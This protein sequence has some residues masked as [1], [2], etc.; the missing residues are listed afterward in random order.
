MKHL[1]NH[2]FILH[3]LNQ[4][5]TIMKFNFNHFTAFILLLFT[6]ILL[7]QTTGFIRHTFGD[8]LAVIGVYCFV[9]S[10]FNITPFKLGIGVLLFSF[11]IEFLQLT[12]FL[13]II[14]LEH[15]RTATIIFG[16]TFSYSDLIAYTLGAICVVFI[17]KTPLLQKKAS[18]ITR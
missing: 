2:P 12:S 18:F 16:N 5:I 10:F 13:K 1:L 8:F 6:E 14:G 11:C 17:D 7:T 9:K 4:S 15:N 3:V